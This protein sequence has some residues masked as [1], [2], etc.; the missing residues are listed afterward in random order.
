ML[1]LPS[2]GPADVRWW[3]V[4]VDIPEKLQSFADRGDDWAGW[5]TGL[6]T[7]AGGLI[8]EWGLTVD[9]ASMHGECALVLPVTSADGVPAVLKVG[10]PHEE[11]DEEHLALRF[12]NG[13]GAVRLLRA[14]PRRSAQLLERLDPVDLTTVPVQAATEII[15][16]LYADLHVPASDEFRRLSTLCQRWTP[17]LEALRSSQALPRRYVDRAAALTRELANDP[18]TDG[19]IV[20]TD[21]H[22]ENVLAA[23]REPWLAIDPKPLS[24]DP[25]FEIAPLLWNRLD[26]AVASGDVRSAIRRRF[27]TLVDVAGLDEERA[28][29]WVVVRMM[30]NAMWET[31]DPTPPS[32]EKDSWL[33]DAI[34]IAKAIDD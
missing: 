10:W 25:C 17:R 23:E 4:R 1:A 8:D 16:N 3:E 27:E 13:R 18:S 11:A 19:V 29:A 2:R 5:L 32:D 34:T 9:G 28:K 24:G 12:W 31:E 30:V 6:S 14:D 15:A 21:L 22:Y 7:L 26:E 33:T 20:H